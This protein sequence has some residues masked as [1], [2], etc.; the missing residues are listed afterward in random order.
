[1]SG[2]QVPVVLIFKPN[3][4]RLPYRMLLR[5]YTTLVN[6]DIRDPMAILTKTAKVA[7]ATETEAAATST[8]SWVIFIIIS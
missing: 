2:E 8:Y 7:D 5:A 1:M 4:V 3:R 6:A